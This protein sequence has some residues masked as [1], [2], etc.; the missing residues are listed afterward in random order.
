MR[1]RSTVS[2]FVIPCSSVDDQKAILSMTNKRCGL[3]N[4]PVKI[5]IFIVKK[6]SGAIAFVFNLSIEQGIFP[7]R[8]N[9]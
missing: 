6:V 3:D 7:N 5:Y 1:V 2:M 8:L 9:V 4:I